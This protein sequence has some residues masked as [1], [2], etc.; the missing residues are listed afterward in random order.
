MVQEQSLKGVDNPLPE[1]NQV[2]AIA[3]AAKVVKWMED[4]C[5]DML[6]IVP[7]PG[8]MMYTGFKESRCAPVLGMAEFLIQPTRHWSAPRFFEPCKHHVP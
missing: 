5:P 3:E 7:L 4:V 6:S 2:K 1:S 8:D